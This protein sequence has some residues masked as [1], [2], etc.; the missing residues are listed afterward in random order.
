MDSLIHVYA[1]TAGHSVWFSEDTGHTWLHPNSH[2]GMYLEARVWCFSSHPQDPSHLFAGTDMGL[3]RWEEASA[4]WQALPSPMADVWAIA[5]DPQ[6]GKTLIAGTR[7]A[8][9]SLDG[10]GSH[11]AGLECTGN[12][13]VF[14]GQYGA[15]ARHANLVRSLGVELGLGHGGDWW[16]LFE[17][18]PRTDLGLVRPRT[19]FE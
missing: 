6:D 15:H 19:D 5:Q 3:F 9:L 13:P 16:H 18:R 1:G 10:F 17:Q 2:S 14:H 4:R 12:Q 11:V 8:V 7:P